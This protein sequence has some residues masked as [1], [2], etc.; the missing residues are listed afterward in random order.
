MNIQ[1]VAMMMNG[2]GFQA[3]TENT[4][5]TINTIKISE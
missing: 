3:L 5:K 2:E 4:R 1:W